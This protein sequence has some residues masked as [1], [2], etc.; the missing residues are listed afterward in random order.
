[1]SIPEKSIRAWNKNGVV[2]CW[3]I[4]IT[5]KGCHTP[6]R[7]SSSIPEGHN[8]MDLTRIASKACSF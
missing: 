7:Q 1:M 4:G 8:A 5:E 2:V 3:G 6:T